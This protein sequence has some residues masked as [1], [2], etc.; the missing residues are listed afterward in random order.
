MDTNSRPLQHSEVNPRPR[1]F[2]RALVLLV[3]AF[4]VVL[5][6]M[7]DQQIRMLSYIH[8]VL[9]F[10]VILVTTI[11]YGQGYT[12]TFCL[13]AA[14]LWGLV[15]VIAGFKPVLL[16]F[17]NNHTGHVN[18]SNFYPEAWTFLIDVWLITLG[19]VI[20]VT[21]RWLIESGRSVWEM[22]TTNDGSWR[23]E[24]PRYPSWLVGEQKNSN[25]TPDK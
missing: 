7:P 11:V 19:G 20:A 2:V 16:V 3:L 23:E 12:R 14:V 15:H 5:L 8:L 25:Q 13:G 24:G 9:V 17:H 1:Q 22:E 10:Y 21:T 18:H 6:F 4:L